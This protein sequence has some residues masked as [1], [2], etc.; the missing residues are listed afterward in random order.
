MVILNR[1]ESSVSLLMSPPVK[2]KPCRVERADP[3]ALADGDHAQVALSVEMLLEDERRAFQ[4]REFG[5]KPVE[6]TGPDNLLSALAVCEVARSQ[7]FYDQRRSE[8]FRYVRGR[9]GHGR[10]RCADA[11]LVGG[12]H[13]KK[14]VLGE[15]QAIER[16]QP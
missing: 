13:L 8:P 4:V 6:R 12:A 1:L 7:R 14:F 15:E 9:R 2:R 11:E 3:H 5:R 10:R 16:G